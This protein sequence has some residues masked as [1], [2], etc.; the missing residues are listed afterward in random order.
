MPEPKRK[1]KLVHKSLI[2]T[3][4]NPKCAAHKPNNG[5]LSG[6]YSSYTNIKKN[7]LSGLNQS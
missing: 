7:T 2:K 5:I 6:G 1:Y 4:Y 3:V